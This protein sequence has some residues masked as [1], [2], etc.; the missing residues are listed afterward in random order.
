MSQG[1]INHLDR[2]QEGDWGLGTRDMGHGARDRGHGTGAMGHGTGDMG[3]GTQ[4]MGHRA[5][6]Y[7]HRQLTLTGK[8]IFLAIFKALGSKQLQIK[9]VKF[10]LYTLSHIY[11][12]H[13]HC[14]LFL[15]LITLE[16]FSERPT[17]QINSKFLN[18]SPK[19]LSESIAEIFGQAL[20]GYSQAI[21]NFFNAFVIINLQFEVGPT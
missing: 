19:K 10:E 15:V 2:I 13:K 8:Q 6:D 21:Q 14:L 3:Q 1:Q 12:G 11:M 4:D 7:G 9:L 16:T 18:S 17:L 20:F 5:T